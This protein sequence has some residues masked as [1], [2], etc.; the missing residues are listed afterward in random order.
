[1]N[2]VTASEVSALRQR[3]NELEAELSRVE[4]SYD[5]GA[6]LGFARLDHDLK[7]LEVSASLAEWA[8]RAQ[9]DFRGQTVEA[10][11]DGASAQQLDALYRR[12]LEDGKSASAARIEL[13]GKLYNVRATP[14]GSGL[15]AVFE[16]SIDAA[17]RQRYRDELQT[18]RERFRVAVAATRA[19]VYDYDWRQGRVD[20]I[21]GV[22]ELTGYPAAQVAPTP[23]AWWQLVHPDDLAVQQRTAGHGLEGS[24]ATLTNQYRIRHHDGSWRW[25]QDTSTVFYDG[26]GEPVR[27]IG[28]TVDVTAERTAQEALRASEERYRALTENLPHMVSQLMPDGLSTFGNRAWREF[29]RRT[30]LTFAEWL[31]VVHPEDMARVQAAWLRMQADQIGE[32]DEFRFRRHDGVYRW[33][34]VTVI[35]IRNA[36]GG[37]ECWVA[38]ATDIHE[39]READQQIRDSEE[40]LRA[41]NHV[42]PAGLFTSTVAGWDYV[43]DSL[44]D[45][46]GASLD[47]MVGDGW[48]TVIHPDDR[49]AVVECWSKSLAGVADFDCE[50]RFRLK[51]QTYRWFHGR[52]VP[53]RE[54]DGPIIRWF[55]AC[56]DTEDQKRSEE[57]LKQAN[58]D[59]AASNKLLEQFAYV[60][61]HDLQEPLRTIGS[62]SQLLERQY[63]GQLDANADGYIGHIVDATGRM[64]QLVMDL[65]AFSRVTAA[66]TIVVES[67]PL[68][69]VWDRVKHDLRQLIQESKAGITAS[70]LPVVEGSSSQLAQV[71]QNLLA[72][73]LKY[74]L[75]DQAPVI[76]LECQER[77]SDWL[78]TLA[79]NGQ[80]F[81]AEYSERIFAAFKRLHGRDIP[82]TGVGLAIVRTIVE[83]HGGRVWAESEGPGKGARFYFTLPKPH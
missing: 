24:P 33:L 19:L 72:N 83:R 14:V 34:Q 49:E 25:V 41:I 57:K 47:G 68:G 81:A 39:R 18:A 2:S 63:R 1:M 64:R 23:E 6:P 13:F 79:D 40:R 60:A 37:L 55:G 65:L 67:V 4:G 51:D 21:C 46:L 42:V 62:F 36:G 82:G 38:T 50:F 8:S 43:S 78:V 35:P 73:A 59:L 76:H 54:M 53:M 77:E 16:A 52:S 17:E 15:A 44:L 27:M 30:Q 7:H 80:G 66:Q 28:L 12:V 20:R 75:E 70:P 10:V 56:W 9:D 71:L 3:I 22:E 74:R 26:A 5:I 31:E 48:L 32:G 69:F 29:F 58:E 45:Q 11:F 61:S